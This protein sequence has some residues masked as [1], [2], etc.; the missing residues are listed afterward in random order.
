MNSMKSEAIHIMNA[1]RQATFIRRERK[2]HHTTFFLEF[3]EGVMTV[4]FYLMPSFWETELVVKGQLR[5]DM[6]NNLMFM[7][8]TVCNQ[9]DSVKAFCELREDLKTLY[10]KKETD[11]T[12]RDKNSFCKLTGRG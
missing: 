12:A 5:V 11:I 8:S 2:D 7:D 10:W 9:A 6:N 3:Q 1:A 4:D